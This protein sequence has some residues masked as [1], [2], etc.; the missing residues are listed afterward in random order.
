MP[1]SGQKVTVQG[2]VAKAK[3]ERNSLLKKLRMRKLVILCTPMNCEAQQAQLQESDRSSAHIATRC[4]HKATHSKWASHKQAKHST[5]CNRAIYSSTT[6][7]RVP[8]LGLSTLKAKRRGAV[9]AK[10]MCLLLAFIPLCHQL[11]TYHESKSNRHPD[12]SKTAVSE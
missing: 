2:Y 3:C 9:L 10:P 4:C 6:A 5:Q 12:V 8:S 1:I 11:P 7:V